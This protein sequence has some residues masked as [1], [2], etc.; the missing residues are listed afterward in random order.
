MPFNQLNVNWEVW[1]CD[2]MATLCH[3]VTFQLHF[4]HILVDLMTKVYP[5]HVNKVCA[6]SIIWF[7]IFFCNSTGILLDTHAVYTFLDTSH[8]ARSHFLDVF[9]SSGC[10]FYPWKNITVKDHQTG[11]VRKYTYYGSPLASVKGMDVMTQLRIN[12]I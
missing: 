8:L 7:W 3:L 6:Q 10:Y 1:K 9:H 4:S 5:V 12:W 11:S 2:W